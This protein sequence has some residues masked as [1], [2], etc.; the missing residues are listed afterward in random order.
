MIRSLLPIQVSP[1]QSASSSLRFPPPG[2]RGGD[3]IDD[4]QPRRYLAEN[5]VIFWEFAAEIGEAD[6]ELTAVG[7]RPGVRH[8]KHAPF[9]VEISWEFIA[10][11]VSRSAGA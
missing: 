3:L 10:E 5:R 9:V 1:A 8:S 7:I 6:E 11:P 2:W 4:L